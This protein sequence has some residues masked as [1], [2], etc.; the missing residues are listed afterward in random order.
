VILTLA[1][2][3]LALMACHVNHVDMFWEAEFCFPYKPMPG[4][5]A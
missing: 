1:L 4:L 3:A 2:M 5:H